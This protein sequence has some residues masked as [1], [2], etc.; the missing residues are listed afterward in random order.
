MIGRDNGRIHARLT[1]A[2]LQA[3]AILVGKEQGPVPACL[4]PARKAPS[5]PIASEV[6]P[7]PPFPE[8]YSVPPVDAPKH[9]EPPESVPAAVIIRPSPPTRATLLPKTDGA[10][11]LD[12]EA[13]RAAVAAHLAAG[14]WHTAGEIARA[15]GLH[16]EVV[17]TILRFSCALSRTMS[18]AEI[19]TRGA[20]IEY[21]ARGAEAAAAPPERRSSSAWMSAYCPSCRKVRPFR[22][23]PLDQDPGGADLACGNCRNIIATLYR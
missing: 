6:P 8:P 10:P 5:W 16:P 13:R 11:L 19:K 22:E 17:R 12:L 21:A 9:P 18:E 23:I 14:G 1:I 7:P 20:L 3:G 4:L 15:T 2:E